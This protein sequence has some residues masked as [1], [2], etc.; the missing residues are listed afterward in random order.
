M[1]QQPDLLLVDDHDENLLA[2]EAILDDPAYNLVRAN[3]GR[4]A[5]KQV[6]ARDFAVILLD[7]VMPDLD[8]YETAELIRGRERSRQT[9]I[10]FLTANYRSD[11][12][13]FKGYS[14]GAVDYLFKPFN[15][16]ILRTKVAVFVELYQKREALTRQTQ[17]LMRAQEE[18]EERVRARTRELAMA[19]D[20]LRAEVEE[21]RRIEAERLELLQR[22]Q[23][24]RSQAES[25]NRLKDEFLATLSHELRTPLNAILGWSHLLTSGRADAAMVDRAIG[26]IRNNAT[27]Q[28][29]LIEDI[30]DVSR[31][32]GGKLRLNI[33]RV[34]LREVI[35]AA[36]DSI[37]PAA[38]AKAITIERDLDDVDTVAGDR[39]RL[40]QVVWNL[41]SNA[42]KFT[43]RDGRISVRL[44]RRDVDMVLTVED[45]GIGIPPDFLP[46]VFDRFSQADGSATRRHGGL[47]LGMAIV[48]YLVELHGGSVSADSGGENQGAKFTIVLPA[49][50]AVSETERGEGRTGAAATVLAAADL[51]PVDGISVLLVDD[52]SDSRNFLSE[53][54]VKQGLTVSTAGSADEALEVF[55]RARPDVLV[56][57]I[58]MP[59]EDGYDLIR[60]VRSLG[61]EDGGRTPAVALTAYVRAEDQR[62]ALDAGYDR[63]I[64]KPV[65]LSEL[66]TAVAQLAH[67]SAAQTERLLTPLTPNP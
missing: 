21:R 64:R 17:A 49:R 65:D 42:V 60:R 47:G 27:A 14:V 11:S 46:Y 43:P 25:V 59:G 41:L 8:G 44:H 62:A 1:T 54:L 19:N 30:L 39:D 38:E 37:A 34:G 58:A 7:V 36:L 32:I 28:S 15:P 48:R 6:L 26:V 51:P 56:S 12:H 10:I 23:A 24:A 35:E 29:Q 3:S 52:D 33:G 61:D 50:P 20:A 2:L 9:P 40:Q 66:V 18:L 22:E 31:I 67:Q 55:D 4:A 63:H 45:T 57:D 16:E 53:L 13:I 5:L